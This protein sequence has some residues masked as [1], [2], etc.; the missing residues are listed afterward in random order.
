MMGQR[1]AARLG[2]RHRRQLRS[3]G[4]VR[5]ATSLPTPGRPLSQQIVRRWQRRERCCSASASTVNS[6]PSTQ[7]GSWW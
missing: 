4:L 7:N 5:R 2:W 6:C 3:A 1:F